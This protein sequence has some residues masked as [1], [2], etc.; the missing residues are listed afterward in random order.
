MQYFI[1]RWTSDL[2]M[3]SI[4]IV[5]FVIHLLLDICI[6]Y[7][8]V[9]TKKQSRSAHQTSFRGKG[10]YIRLV[11][12]WF[13]WFLSHMRSISVFINVFN[14]PMSLTE[15]SSINLYGITFYSMVKVS[16]HDN[17]ISNFS[18][19]WTET[20]VVFWSFNI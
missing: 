8:Y 20:L 10:M 9:Q 3:L 7:N 12:N 2:S 11:I 4:R 14:L 13:T 16:V 15:I 1:L 5:S 17:M 6:Y 18:L 19:N